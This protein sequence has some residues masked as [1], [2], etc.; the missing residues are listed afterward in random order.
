MLYSS[1]FLRNT[2]IFGVNLYTNK[3]FKSCPVIK[4]KVGDFHY[5]DRQ[6][7][8]EFLRFIFQRTVFLVLQTRLDEQLRVTF[9]ATF[10]N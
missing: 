6:R 5:M 2:K 1:L 9:V 3:C 8:P 7:V 10:P 4:L